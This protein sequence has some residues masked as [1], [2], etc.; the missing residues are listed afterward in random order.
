MTITRL[1]QVPMLAA[2]LSCKD[3]T[4]PTLRPAITSLT[5]ASAIAGASSVTITINGS[6]F[7]SASQVRWNGA[8]LPTTFVSGTQLTAVVGAAW[9]ASFATAEITVHSPSPGGTSRP[10]VFTVFGSGPLAWNVSTVT[11]AGSPWDVTIAPNGT[12]YATRIGVASVLR[13]DITR[14]TTA[15]TFPTDLWPYEITFNKSGSL[16]W[17]THAVDNTVAVIDAATHQVTDSWT[18]ASQPIRLRLNSAETKLYVTHTNGTVAVVNPTTGEEVSPK[19]TIGGVLNGIALTPDGS[20]LWVANTRGLVREIN[21]R[22]DAAARSISMGGV[23]QDV[24]VSRDGSTLYVANEAGWV[25]AYNLATLAQVDS[26]PVNNAFGLGL[27]HHGALLWVT[28]GGDG[29]VSV[30]YT[31]DRRLAGTIT[32]GGTARHVAFSANNAAVIANENGAIHVA[33]LNP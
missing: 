18:M 29:M 15:G 31:A 19:I 32:T 23:P 26:I 16:A 6:G 1:L 25:G 27:S 33:R 9:L 11:V 3:A 13:L 2:L 22:T 10:A 17:A 8:D 30:Y 7:S 5:P 28:R 24:V 4:T 20:R 14:N 21:T 12:A